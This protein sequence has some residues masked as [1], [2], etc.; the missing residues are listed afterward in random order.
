MTKDL[1]A[2][3]DAELSALSKETYDAAYVVGHDERWV[4]G[5]QAYNDRSLWLC[6]VEEQNRRGSVDPLKIPVVRE[7]WVRYKRASAIIQKDLN[8]KGATTL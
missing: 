4:K 3:S 7:A 5:T 8:S 1:T 2:L 6:V